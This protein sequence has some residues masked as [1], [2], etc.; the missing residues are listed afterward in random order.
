MLLVVGM[1]K[2]FYG[3]IDVQAL[4][5]D[6]TARN[7]L[8]EDQLNDVVM[9]EVTRSLEFSSFLMA[10]FSAFCTSP[11]L[12]NN[13]AGHVSW[14]M[15]GGC[16]VFSHSA[17]FAGGLFLIRLHPTRLVMSLSTFP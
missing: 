8:T 10:S 9:W 16:E 5:Q 11:N 6:V 17:C 3:S 12:F 2:H 4:M 14:V 15:R 13:L 7:I 1:D